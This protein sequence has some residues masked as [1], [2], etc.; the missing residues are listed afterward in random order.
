M[1][2]LDKILKMLFKGIV[3]VYRTVFSAIF[4][5]FGGKCR[6]YPTCSSYAL[7][8]LDVHGGLKGGWLTLK[9]FAKCGPFHEGGHDPVP[10]RKTPSSKVQ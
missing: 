5:Q 8:A 9:R 3:I 10:K 7:E 1:H 4:R 2:F 6:F